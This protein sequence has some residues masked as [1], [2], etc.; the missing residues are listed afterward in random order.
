MRITGTIQKGVGQGAFF[1]EL[2]WVVEQFEKAM[3]F[4]PFP[5]TLNVRVADEDMPK[6]TV[7][8]S[9]MD[10]EIV[11][12]DPDYCVG[13]FKRIRVNGVPAAVVF[14]EEHVHI[15]G[16]EI[17]EIMAAVHIKETFNLAD[18]DP[19]IITEFHT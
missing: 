2:P 10:F 4:K 15:H 16:K 14:P 13:R 9:K 11:P 7:F 12:S 8:F 5:G 3:G 18:G 17:I 6:L 19:V 1:T